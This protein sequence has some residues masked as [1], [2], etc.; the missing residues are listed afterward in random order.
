MDGGG[1]PVP[2]GQLFQI[3]GNIFQ[4]D[5]SRNSGQTS[6]VC[7]SHGVL[8]LCVGKDTLNGFFSLGAELFAQCCFLDRLCSAQKFLPDIRSKY[9]LS[10]SSAPHRHLYRHCLHLEGD[11]GI[12]LCLKYRGC[13]TEENMLN[14]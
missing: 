9:L 1:P 2:E 7:I 13:A 3:H 6:V 14:I 10:F 12:A 11:S 8:L 5:P 4:P